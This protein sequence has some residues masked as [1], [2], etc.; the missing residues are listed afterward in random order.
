MF[1]HMKSC[2]IILGAL[3]VFGTAGTASADDW[4]A[5]HIRHQQHELNEA[6][7][8]HGYYSRQADRER[9]ELDRVLDQCR[10]RDRDGYRGY[11]HFR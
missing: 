7:K 8:H 4:C 5:K 6:I 9:R 3:L 2:A 11:D 1:K 10:V